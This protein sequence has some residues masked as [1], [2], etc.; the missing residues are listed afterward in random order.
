MSNKGLLNKFYL[1]IY[2]RKKSQIS[3]ILSSIFVNLV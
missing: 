3:L 2:V 1:N